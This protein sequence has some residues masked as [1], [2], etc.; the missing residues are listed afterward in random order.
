MSG[1]SALNLIDELKLRRWA[2]LNYVRPELR[3]EDW[4]PAILSEMT[5]K[6]EELAENAEISSL[7]DEI[8]PV[9]DSRILRFDAAHPIGRANRSAQQGAGIRSEF[10]FS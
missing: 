6:D 7:G 3:S 9:R 8:V 4:H 2:R 10:H 5:L 1:P